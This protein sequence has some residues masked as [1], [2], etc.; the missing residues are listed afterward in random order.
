MAIVLYKVISVYS[1]KTPT[2]LILLLCI[3]GIAVFAAGCTSQPSPPVSNITATPVPTVVTTGT[4]ETIMIL[5][6]QDT[7]TISGT[8]TVTSTTSPG[9]TTPSPTE[10][11]GQRI[12]IKAKNLVFD[13]SRIT[14]PASSQVIVEFENEDPVAHNVAFYTTSSL[15]ETIYKGEII[16]GPGKVTYTFTAPATPGTYYFHCDVHPFMNGQFVVT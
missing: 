5:G 15:T 13:V 16:T 8:P 11:K 10:D 6:T 12:R 2:I 14:V 3:S 9:I 1:M 4:S 7:P